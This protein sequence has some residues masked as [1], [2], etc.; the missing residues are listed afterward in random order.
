MVKKDQNKL[1]EGVTYSTTTSFFLASLESVSKTWLSEFE[2]NKKIFFHKL[3]DAKFYY[4]MFL[5][6]IN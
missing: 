6:I 2:K 5:E 1:I 3:S 4:Q